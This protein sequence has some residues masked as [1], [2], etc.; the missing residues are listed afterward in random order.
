MVGPLKYER[1][2]NI[3]I[4]LVVKH[5]TEIISQ[6][7]KSCDLMETLKTSDPKEYE[8]WY[9][10]YNCELNYQGSTPSMESVGATNLFERSVDKYGLGYTSFSGHGDRKLQFC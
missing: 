8:L 2:T 9:A 4:T 6:H 10:A 5:C 7:W 1:T 3:P